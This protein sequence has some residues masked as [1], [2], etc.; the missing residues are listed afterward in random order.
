MA[1]GLLKRFNCRCYKLPVIG[2]LP[3]T[4]LA[5]GIIYSLYSIQIFHNNFD[6]KSTY[7]LKEI[8]D[9]VFS[10]EFI[11]EDQI[12]FTN[13]FACNICNYKYA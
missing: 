10:K 5:K 13:D 4:I 12:Y 1:E 6:N 11:W 8:D 2:S 9:I 7:L 3:I